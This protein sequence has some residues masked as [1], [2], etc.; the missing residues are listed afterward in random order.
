MAIRSTR[1]QNRAVRSTQGGVTL[2][3]RLLLF[4]T[5]Y[6]FLAQIGAQYLKY[7]YYVV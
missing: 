3:F 5:F 7:V 4:S 2:L 6:D 1:S